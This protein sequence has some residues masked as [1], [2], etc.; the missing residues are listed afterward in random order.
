MARFVNRQ[1]YETHPIDMLPH[2][3]KHAEGSVL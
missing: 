1:R 3:T 2:D